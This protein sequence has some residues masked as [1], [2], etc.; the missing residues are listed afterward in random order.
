MELKS[1]GESAPRP[2]ISNE[3]IIYTTS[4]VNDDKL[5]EI[6]VEQ[7]I[8]EMVQQQY[9]DPKEVDEQCIRVLSNANCSPS[10]IRTVLQNYA[11]QKDQRKRRK[12]QPIAKPG[13][14][15]FDIFRYV[16]E[17]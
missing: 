4:N 14:Y 5:N 16:K 10:L 17:K 13:P 8:Q 2:C 3:D 11:S 12:Q 1:D 7:V 15:I 6:T 9:L